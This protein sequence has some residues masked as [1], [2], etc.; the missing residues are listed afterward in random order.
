MKTM[1]PTNK[2]EWIL[3]ISGIILLPLFSLYLSCK[4]SLFYENLTYVG[5]LAINRKLFIL[6]GILQSLFYFISFWY[7]YH[8]LHLQK[9]WML[10]LSGTITILSI[11]AFLLPYT[12][13]SGDLF[14]QLHVYGSIGSCIATY[15]IIIKT[16][17]DCIF[18]HFDYYVICR[19]LLFLI[20][21]AFGFSIILLGDISTLSELILLDG[22]NVIFIF[23]ILRINE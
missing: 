21:S 3:L 10:P 9:K 13:H 16:I 19:K 6:W 15:W 22:L 4:T 8:K 1:K 20:L 7:L 14:S 5:N 18:Y 12:N 17:Y 23:M 11:I 2:I